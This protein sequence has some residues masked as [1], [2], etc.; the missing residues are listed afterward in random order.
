MKF[1]IVENR[2]IIRI[3]FKPIE[4]FTICCTNVRIQ[5]QK[6]AITLYNTKNTINL[7]NNKNIRH[8]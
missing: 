5:I 3:K 4:R 6:Q 2:D 1:I 7:Q 8:Q